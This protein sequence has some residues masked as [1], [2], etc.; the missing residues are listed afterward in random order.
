MNALIIADDDFALNSLPES[1]ADILISCGDLANDSI[2]RAAARCEC[3]QVLAVKG[4]HD[5][6]GVFPPSIT[7]LHL[8]TIEFAGLQFG[9]FCGSWKYKPRGN[10]LFDQSEVESA[11][12]TFPRVDVFV[13]HNSPFQVHDKDDE[14]HTG[15]VSF[16]SYIVK[17]RPKYFLHGHQH[18]SKETMVGGTR[19]IGTYGYRFQVISA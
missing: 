19:V 12:S 10:F 8:R 14:V 18:I 11:L 1:R 13:A 9:G 16:V 15:F 2:N 5:S 4:N 7:D 6:S 17:H 3:K